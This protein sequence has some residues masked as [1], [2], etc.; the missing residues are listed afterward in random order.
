MFYIYFYFSFSFSLSLSFLSQI[1]F[2]IMFKY[3]TLLTPEEICLYEATLIGKKKLVQLGLNNVIKQGKKRVDGL[4]GFL[5]TDLKWYKFNKSSKIH[6]RNERRKKKSLLLQNNK[7]QF[8]FST[9]NL[10]LLIHNLSFSFFSIGLQKNN[11]FF[12]NRSPTFSV[13]FLSS[14]SSF[15]LSSCLKK[16]FR[17]SN[18][19]IN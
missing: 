10:F 16:T 4:I 1:R 14:V 18:E 9:G 7:K 3:N 12:F 11:F 15:I 8:F 19:F 17:I 6:K 5:N 2:Q 13:F